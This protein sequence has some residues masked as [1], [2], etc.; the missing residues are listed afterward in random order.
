MPLPTPRD[1]DRA[2]GSVPDGP[3]KRSKREAADR[4]TA[5]SDGGPWISVRDRPG[6]FQSATTGR[7]KYDPQLNPEWRA[8]LERRAKAAA[9]KSNSQASG[10]S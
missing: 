6:L 5:I 10:S 8:D 1:G 7:F 4:A 2:A 3:S 9:S